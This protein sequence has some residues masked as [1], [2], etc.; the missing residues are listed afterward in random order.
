MVVMSGA[1][2][3]GRLAAFVAK[4]FQQHCPDVYQDRLAYLC[5]GGEAALLKSQ[6]SAEDV[7]AAAVADLSQLLDGVQGPVVYIGISCGMSATYVGA[8]AEELLARPPPAG[9]CVCLLGFN[10]LSLVPSK[11]IQGW[12]STYRAVAE[13]V[14]EAQQRT[15]APGVATGVLLTPA[16]GPEAIAG[17]TR[18]KGGSATKL[19]LE[20]ALAAAAAAKTAAQ[21]GGGGQ[22]VPADA[23]LARLKSAQ[24]AVEAVY[25]H[26]ASL[27]AVVSRAA[28][29]LQCGGRVLY[30]GAGSAGVLGMIDASECPPTYGASFDDVRGFVQGGYHCL[31]QAQTANTIPA[32]NVTGSRDD[33]PGHRLISEGGAVQWEMSGLVHF[34][35][36]VSS[37]LT[38]QDTVIILQGPTVAPPGSAVQQHDVLLQEAAAAAAACP[39]A[40][41]A[42]AVLSD[43]QEAAQWLCDAATDGLV[44]IRVGASAFGPPLLHPEGELALKLALN[45]VTTVAHVQRGCVYGNHM[46]DVG[47]TNAKL[48]VRAVGIIADVA[49]VSR[50]MAS[51]ALLR[52]IREDDSLEVAAATGEH[53]ADVVPELIAMA[54][55][56]RSLVPLSI[57]MCAAAKATPPPEQAAGG[58]ATA[59]LI[60]V[61]PSVQATKTA[62]AAHPVLREAIRAAVGTSV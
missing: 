59:G 17:S 38:E 44:A 60:A 28:H 45:A 3:S 6:E 14:A 4:E 2:T 23:L 50:R 16:V 51:T 1:G 61:L 24:A 56:K 10:P 5:A 33:P 7:S 46:I 20:T 52:C 15:A 31:G 58:A 53:A 9:A 13:L 40:V 30:I 29:S 26:N 18:M 54:S 43:G 32:T 27:A 57:L 55:K 19:L 36:H 39:A 49:G 11:A 48:L 21:G 35:E 25:M 62:L 8:Q 12:S 47:V 37:T 41:C 22:G 34:T 42:V